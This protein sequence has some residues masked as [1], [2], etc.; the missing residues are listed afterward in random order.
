MKLVTVQVINFDFHNAQI[1]IVALQ[2]KSQHNSEVTSAVHDDV[3]K[4]ISLQCDLHL[5][6]ACRSY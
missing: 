6:P 4:C 3:N 5:S 2:F 1:F